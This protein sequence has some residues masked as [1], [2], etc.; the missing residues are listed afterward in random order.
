M[1]DL[2]GLHTVVCSVLLLGVL[3]LLLLICLI[4][5]SLAGVSIVMSFCVYVMNGRLWSLL[6]FYGQAQ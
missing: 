6:G 4:G 2:S 5:L 1:I 3:A